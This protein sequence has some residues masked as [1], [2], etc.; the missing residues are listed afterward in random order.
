MQPKNRRVT[1]LIRNSQERS[2]ETSP[3]NG[4]PE[5]NSDKDRNCPKAWVSGRAYMTF[6]SRYICSY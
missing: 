4:I 1:T 3:S 5:Y 6:T 2:W